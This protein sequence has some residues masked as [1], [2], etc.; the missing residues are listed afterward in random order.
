MSQR[1]IRLPEV[2]EM[3]GLS[4]S[5]IYLR[6]SKGNFPQSISLGERAVGWLENDVERWLDACITA[7]KAINDE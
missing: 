3:T 2:K 4:R 7:S 1:I 6:M 5:T